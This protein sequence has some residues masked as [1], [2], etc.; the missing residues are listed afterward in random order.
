MLNDK[1]RL[2]VENDEKSIFVVSGAGTGKTTVIYE[3][4]LYLISKKVNSESI[5][6][7]S[8]T[9]RTVND[10]KMKFHISADN[11]VIKTF[12]GL[13]FSHVDCFIS[14]R[15]IE[16]DNPLLDAYDRK[17]LQEMMA[18]KGLL[19][20]KNKTTKPL[21][22]Y[23]AIL[24][25]NDLFDYVDFEVQFYHELKDITFRKELQMMYSYIFIDEAQDMSLIQV[26]IL[27][28]LVSP[29]TFLFMVGDPDQ[30]IYAFRGSQPDMVST[31]IKTFSC[32]TIQLDDTYR[33]ATGI[34]KHAN[35]LIKYNRNRLPKTLISHKN[36]PGIIEYHE[37]SDSKKEANFIFTKITH[38]LHQKYTQKDIVILVRKHFYSTEIKRVLQLSYYPDVDCLSIHQAK[39]LEYPIVIIMGIE[40]LRHLTKKELEEERRLFFV[41]MTRAKEVLIMTSFQNKKTPKFIK[42]CGVIVTKH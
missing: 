21:S 35:T 3:R 23:Q 1:Q 27:K 31:L 41:A 38:F 20:F 22:D 7:I 13:A 18:K 26:E 5:L 32:K 12:H 17:D 10:I 8:F 36:T 42:E 6:V 37:F 40:E 2:A 29:A 33:C 30:S 9:N 4:I 24:D 14:K 25:K 39:G 11:P 16:P 15:L 28:L 19:T 34:V